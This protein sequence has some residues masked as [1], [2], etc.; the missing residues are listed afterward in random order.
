MD[1]VF[2]KRGASLTLAVA[3]LG[4]VEAV[5]VAPTQAVDEDL[6]L[7]GGD[8]VEPLGRVRAAG[9][10]VRLQL[11]PGRDSCKGHGQ[12]RHRRVCVCVCARASCVYVCVCVCARARVYVCVCVCVC[13]CVRWVGRWMLL[14]C[15]SQQHNG[16]CAM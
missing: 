7:L 14:G 3:V 12:V 13:V 8:V 4:C 5:V 10:R 11:A 6:A 1:Q 15:I 16:E 2:K 9:T